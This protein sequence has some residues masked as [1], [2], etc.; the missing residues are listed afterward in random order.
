LGRGERHRA[1]GAGLAERGP[2]FAHGDDGAFERLG[3]A[4]EVSS[5]DVV[6]LAQIA[7]R[8]AD[9]EPATAERVK[10]RDGFGRKDRMAIR[11][12]EDVGEKAEP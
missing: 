5:E 4:A 7:D 8:R 12:N 1:G 3:P 11:E 6:L 9:N 2:R 10:R